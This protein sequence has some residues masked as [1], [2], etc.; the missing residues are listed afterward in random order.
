MP[1]KIV[2]SQVEAKWVRLRQRVLPAPLLRQSLDLVALLLA[3]LLYFHIDVQLQIV[4]LPSL[5]R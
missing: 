2:K 3:F 4:C 1:L 5:F